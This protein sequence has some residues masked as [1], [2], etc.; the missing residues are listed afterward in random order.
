[1][2]VTFISRQHYL[3]NTI[4]EIN[5]SLQKQWQK[6]KIQIANTIIFTIKYNIV[7]LHWHVKELSKV[8]F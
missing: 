8:H 4:I 3:F 7:L 6:K 2:Y 5:D 1:M